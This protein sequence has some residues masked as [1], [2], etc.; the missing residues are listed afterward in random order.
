[1]YFERDFKST[2]MSTYIIPDIHGCY[3][4]LKEL[5]ESILKVSKCDRLYFLGDYI[6]RGPSSAEVVEYLINLKT[7]EYNVGFIKG[8][9]EQMLL[10]SIV[11]RNSIDN[12]L[13]NN[14]NTTI[15]SYKNIYGVNYDDDFVNIIPEKHLDFYFNL[16]PYLVIDDKYVLVHGGLNYKLDDP[17][18]DEQGMLWRRPEPIPE[19]FLP[20]KVIL[21][22]HTPTS[23]SSIIESINNN[24]RQIGLDAGCVYKGR[25]AGFGYLTALDVEK[26]N[27]IWIENIDI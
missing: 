18:L 25:A 26:W 8:N 13:L 9:H 1:M 2:F 3:K 16:P 11:N 10:D 21:Y 14:G 5:I 24:S 27:L 4:T 22:G 6:D 23:L 12:W 20:N 15:E 7:D 17:F 19:T